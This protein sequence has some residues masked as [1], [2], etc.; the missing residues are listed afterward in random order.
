[1]KKPILIIFNLVFLLLAYSNSLKSANSKSKFTEFYQNYFKDEEEN[2]YSPI[3]LPIDHNI[4][5]TIKR[6]NNKNAL[7]IGEKGIIYFVTDYN[8][9]ERNIF[10]ASDIEEKTKFKTKINDENQNEYN[11]NCKLWKPIN[12]YIRIICN[13]DE[14]LKYVDNNITLLNSV[15]IEYKNFK[16]EINQE[17]YIEAKQLNYSIP[18]L[19]SNKQNIEIKDHIESYN[20]K[21]KFESYNNEVVFIYGQS[22]NYASLDNCKINDNEL[23]CE[24]SKRKLEEVVGISNEI[25]KVKVINDNVGIIQMDFVLNINISYTINKKKDIYIGITRKLSSYGFENSP[26]EIYQSDN[27][28]FL[29]SYQQ[30]INIDDDKDSYQ[31]KFIIESYNNEIF[32]IGGKFLNIKLLNNCEINEKELTCEIKKEDLIEILQKDGGN[33]FLYYWDKNSE[34]QK[35]ENVIITVNAKNIQKEDIYVGINK[36]LDN[37]LQE[38]NFVAY[39]T[40]VTNISN[41]I[42]EGGQ[43]K[44]GENE[45]TCYLKKDPNKPLLILCTGF[46]KGKHSLGELINEEIIL[47]NIN[48]KYNF[49]I[50]PT[51]NNEIFEIKD[52]GSYISFS[53]P[54]IL[55][56]TINNEYEI[57]FLNKSR[58]DHFY[59]N[60]LRLDPDLGDLKCRSSSYTLTCTIQSDYFENHPNGYYNLYQLNR[61]K[62][63]SILYEV[64]PFE[65]I[66]PKTKNINIK[67]KSKDNEDYFDIGEKGI[68]YFI[69]N[70]NDNERNIFDPSDIEEKTKFEAKIYNNV[71]S[72]I[73][74]CRLWKPN[75]DNLRVICK[76]N[77]FDL[78]RFFMLE[79]V[80]LNYNE[81]IINISLEKLFSFYNKDYEIP[82]LYSD[83][84]IID[85]KDD[86]E[87]YNLKFN[88]EI[89]NNELLYLYGEVNNSLILDKC[90]KKEKELNCKVTKEK[91]EEILTKNNEQFRVGALHD[92]KGLVKFI[93]VLNI[94]INYKID[95]KEDIYIGIIGTLTKE[96]DLLVPF[97]FETNV[98][99]ISNIYSD[100]IDNCYFKKFNDNPLLFLCRLDQTPKEPFSFGNITNEIVLNNLHYK[101][102]FRI[103]PFEEIYNVTIKEI[104]GIVNLIFPEVLDFTA[105]DTLTITLI[106]PY[107]FIRYLWFNPSLPYLECKHLSEV[108]KCNVSVSHFINLKSGN[109]YLYY[110]NYNYYSK[111]Y[112]GLSPIKVIL[113][114]SLVEIPINYEDNYNYIY[115]G[116]KGLLY[117]KT[118]YSDDV[119]NIFDA[120]DIEEKTTFVTTLNY[121]TTDNNINCRLWKPLNEKMWLFCKL[122]VSLKNEIDSLQINDAVFHYKE[123]TIAVVF[124]FPNFN[125]NFIVNT[126]NVSV[127]FLYSD[128]QIIDIKEEIDSYDLKFHIGI[129]NKE[130][131]CLSLDEMKNIILQDCKEN[132][133]DLIC[134]IKKEKF[135]EIFTTSGQK[136]KLYPCDYSLKKIKF[137]LVNDIIVNFD[138]VQKED[139]FIGITK[140]LDNNVNL[141]TYA[142]YETNITN[143]SDIIS[144][145]FELVFM[146]GRYSEGFTCRIKK[147]I[148]APLLIICLMSRKETFYLKEIIIEKI[149]ENINVKYNFRIQPVYIRDECEVREEGNYIKFAY[150]IVLNYYLYDT[151]NIDCYWNPYSY[152]ELNIILNSDSD[153]LTCYNIDTSIQKCIVPKSHFDGKESGYYPLLHLNYLNNQTIAYQLSPIQVIL[154][155]ENEIIIRIEKEVNKDIIKIGQKGILYL[156]TNFIDQ[157]H[158]FKDIYIPFNSTIKDENNYEYNVN[159]KLWIPN[160]EK[161]RIICKLNENLMS[162]H[163]KILLNKVEFIYNNY[164]IMIFQQDHFEVEQ[165]NYDISFL[166][167]DKQNIE[168]NEG[169]ES[170][171]FKFYIEKYNDETLYIYG[172]RNNSI[173]LDNCE[174]NENELNCEISKEKL[175]EI[176]IKNNEQFKVGAINDT[177]GIINFDFIL[178]ININYKIDNKEDIYIEITN[179]ISQYSQEGTPIAFETNVTNIPSINSDIFD[180]CYFKKNKGTPLLYIC[181][182]N[183]STSSYIIS[184]ELIMNNS[185]YKYNFRIQPFKEKYYFTIVDIG[186]SINLAYPEI[187]NF[188]SEELLTIKFII[189]DP[190]L[191]KNLKFVSDSYYLECEDVNGIKKCIVPLAHFIG[192]K[193]EYYYLNQT[194]GRRQ[195]SFF[196]YESFPIKVILPGNLLEIYVKDEDN[197]DTM[198][199]GKNGLLNFVTNY[200]DKKDIFDISDI[201]EKTYFNTTISIENDID[202]YFK[203]TCRLWKPKNDKIR[204]LCKLNEGLIYG[205]IKINSALFSYKKYKIAIVSTLSFKIQTNIVPGNVPFLYSDKNIINIEEDKQYY[206]FK[207]K[208][209]EYNN[210]V[211]F[212]QRKKMSSDTLLTELILEDC[213]AEEKELTCKIEKEKL[214]ESLFY[215]GEKFDLAFF[216]FNTQYKFLCVLDITINYNI[217]KKEDVFVGVTKLL[218][219]NL[220][221]MNY[222]P[223]ETNITSISNVISAFFEYTTNID[224][225]YCKMKKSATK[226]LLF[227]CFKQNIYTKY[228]LGEN[229]TEVILNNIHIKYNFRIQP[230]NRPEEFI[231]KIDRIGIMIRYPTKLDFNKN[232]LFQIYFILVNPIYFRG[233]RL[234]PESEELDCEELYYNFKIKKCLVPKTHFNGKE[235]GYYYTYYLNGENGLNINYDISPIL[236]S[237]P[238]GD[239]L[240]INIKKEDN[241]NIIKIGNKGTI[242]LITDY[243]D[244]NDIFNSSDIEE[245]TKFKAE[246]FGNK[247]YEANC[248]LWKPKNERIRMIC[249][250][251]KNLE[252]G[253]IKLNRVYSEYKGKNF[254]IYSDVNFIVEQL[255]SNIAFLYSDKQEIYI[256]NN[257]D[258]YEIIFKKDAYYNEP[259]ILYKNEMK[260]INLECNEQEK[261]I[262]C[263]INKDKLLEI[264]SYN[265]ENFYLAQLTNSEGLYI[266]DSV[267]NITINYNKIEKKDIYINITKILTEFTE[268][269]NFIVYETNITDINKITTDYFILTPER[270]DI[271]ECFFK[272]NNQKNKNDE[273]LLLLCKA[274]IPGKRSLGEIKQINLT[275]INMLYN[276]IIVNSKNEEEYTISDMQGTIISLVYPEELDFNSKD[277]YIIRY[278]TDYPERLK[279]IK[280][281]IESSDKLNCEDK[282]GFKQ[283][284]VPKNHFNEEGYYYT[285]YDNSLGNKSIA[286]EAS[287]IKIINLKENNSDSNNNNNLAGIIAGFVVGGLVLIVIIVF[288]IVRYYRRKNATNDGFSGKIENMQLNLIKDDDI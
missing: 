205:K 268:K 169:I 288:F 255:N 104:G 74:N 16:I 81:Y 47:D 140:L 234:N 286:Y 155:K 246:F 124:H 193:S 20:L 141:N 283:C 108:A 53:Y 280:L 218:Q 263:N 33:L 115:I 214:I 176:L 43:Y 100:I 173:I 240:I 241:K 28:P 27:F 145:S 82:F 269:N 271:L 45:Y 131:L 55:D 85:I 50:Q 64:S 180:L 58:I 273:K 134:N 21:F 195:K 266:Y 186:T 5:L 239:V 63:Y 122:N 265:G 51:I 17:A 2:K 259:L 215:N 39:E 78:E 70:Y 172:E 163:Q 219:K 66:L 248:R 72:N 93:G 44:I 130:P 221:Y 88:I 184:K 258:S 7:K 174:K 56:F 229:K 132:G 253:N 249:K 275:Q 110:S 192:K 62:S 23:N 76:L 40:N 188:T 129:Y 121:Y 41:L 84:Q 165:I 276:F 227:L 22:N 277:S 223:Y 162:N 48:I 126:L 232:D 206:D 113:P 153:I 60:N 148:Q 160:S 177:I 77:N 191:V 8:D 187:L 256:K 257:T 207:F 264:L 136:L 13:L 105:K 120:S 25:F 142:A 14:N 159:C 49:R 10:D 94:T 226:P 281:N 103:Q 6:S 230:V 102:N 149:F 164:N 182:F 95:K 19:Y 65:V 3:Y 251:D 90:Q 287:A 238:K 1:M 111:K 196:H 68:I 198:T 181:N 106:M 285:Y 107:L 119:A 92:N 247:N 146:Y 15:Q 109:F 220:D 245:N 46:A 243:Y 71:K 137:N 224:T 194:N 216:S 75:Y 24:I 237:L 35:Y 183:S 73:I 168:I 52:Y 4:N 69:T 270:N 18:F 147:S 197:K 267:L 91:L 236:V 211:L 156:T 254:T 34:I 200:T 152:R 96:I 261:Q 209:E 189:S 244:S 167:S 128:K 29:Y 208:I 250:F 242:S 157:S 154:P 161:L 203:V 54:K 123:F 9:N 272:N 135:Y 150:P 26:D 116:D 284:I 252:N 101:Y 179:L 175:E 37:T 83:R 57:Y 79:K 212:F 178:N 171:N 97:G 228:S 225:Y 199:I 170:Y 185:H 274:L 278:V 143:I 204:L 89:Y 282:N 38:G 279:G 67:I 112:Y 30:I 80:F 222:I 125:R 11:A 31:L 114:N 99:N 118:N 139:I 210:E 190:S 86:I 42:T 138:S 202:Y 87:S 217:S 166:Y 36:L 98:T 201:E 133:K 117:L 127:P 32:L 144:D 61:L 231:L 151:I 233:I 59:D 158:I 12:D 260:K 262:I 213:N 235:S